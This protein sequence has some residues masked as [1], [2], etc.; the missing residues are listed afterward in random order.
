MKRDGGGVNR[1]IK[2]NTEEVKSCS[3]R[4]E[5]GTDDDDRD[6]VREK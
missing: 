5:R 3:E 6:D 4:R 1:K 2:L